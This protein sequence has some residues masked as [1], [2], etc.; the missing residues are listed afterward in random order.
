MIQQTK[1]LNS[2]NLFLLNNLLKIHHIWYDKIF[3]IYFKNKIFT[4]I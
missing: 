4:K 1:F 2:N 3:K